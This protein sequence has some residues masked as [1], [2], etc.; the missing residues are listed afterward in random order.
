MGLL[1]GCTYLYQAGFAPREAEFV[2]DLFAMTGVLASA[3][4]R[5]PSANPMANAAYRHGLRDCS[6][7]AWPLRP[8]GVSLIPQP[9]A[10]IGCRMLCSCADLCCARVACSLVAC[11]L[12]GTAHAIPLCNP[13][14]LLSVVAWCFL[15]KCTHATPE[16][17]V[18]D[19]WLKAQGVSA[20]CNPGCSLAVPP[21]L[22]SDSRVP[23]LG[24]SSLQL[25]LTSGKT[26]SLVAR[27]NPYCFFLDINVQV[28]SLRSRYIP[29]RILTGPTVRCATEQ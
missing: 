18:V 13:M 8:R 5:I 21:I 14:V 4:F 11:S 7:F 29:S 20:H 12:T 28:T 22:H 2:W 3:S 17:L 19:R 9:N 25:P 16:T 6:T 27:V 26:H 1:E 15:R 24:S 23:C 10:R